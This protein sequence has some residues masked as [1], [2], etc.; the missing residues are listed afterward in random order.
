MRFSIIWSDASLKQLRK[1]QRHVAK[2]IVEAV[3]KL[4]EDPYRHVKKVVGD[5]SFRLRVGDYRV[6]M[7]I[8]NNELRIEV[9]KVKHRKSAYE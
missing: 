1:L 4:S 8:K 3:D 2:R 6:F 5:D 7:D 9:L